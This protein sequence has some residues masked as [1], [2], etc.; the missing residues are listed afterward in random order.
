MALLMF[1]N[2]F[3]ITILKSWS[4]ASVKLLSQELLQWCWLLEEASILS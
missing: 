4:W 2:M 3:I 1:L